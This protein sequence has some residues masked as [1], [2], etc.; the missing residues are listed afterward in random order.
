MSNRYTAAVEIPWRMHNPTGGVSLVNLLEICVI[1]IAYITYRYEFQK[2]FNTTP[3]TRDFW[4]PRID[5]SILA[6]S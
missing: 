4:Y 2:R 6:L 3:A 1:D 5:G